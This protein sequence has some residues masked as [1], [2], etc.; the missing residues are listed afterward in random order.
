MAQLGLKALALA[1][2]LGARAF[3]NLEPS[4]RWGLRLG[5]AWLWPEPRLFA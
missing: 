1:W 3:Q 5:P 2:L 4:R